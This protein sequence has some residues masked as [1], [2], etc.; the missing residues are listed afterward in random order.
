MVIMSVNFLNWEIRFA[1]YLAGDF[2]Y[3][4]FSFLVFLD[5]SAPVTKVL[6]VLRYF[7][8]S[9]AGK[10]E[11]C[12]T[13]VTV[14]NLI[15]IRI[16]TT[17]TDLTIGFKKLFVR[18]FSCFCRLYLLHALKHLLEHLLSLILGTVLNVADDRV[19]HQSLLNFLNL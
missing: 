14:K 12:V 2:P 7:M 18:D 17:E 16:K 3:V 6:L 19:M 10:M 13:H 1:A 5:G 4:V 8:E 15:R 11:A 9:V